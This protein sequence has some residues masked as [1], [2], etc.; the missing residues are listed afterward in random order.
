M[1]FDVYTID[2][3]SINLAL[4]DLISVKHGAGITKYVPFEYLEAVSSLLNKIISYYEDDVDSV[5]S[6][7]NDEIETFLLRLRGDKK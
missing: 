3:S 5:S 6:A 2:L 1:S 4:T 7:K